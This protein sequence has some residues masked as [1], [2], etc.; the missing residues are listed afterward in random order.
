MKKCN[1]IAGLIVC[2]A[3]LF[4]GCVN[5]GNYVTKEYELPTESVTST[6]EDIN[7]EDYRVQEGAMFS[8]GDL[9]SI[10]GMILENVCFYDENNLVAIFL[11]EEGTRLDAY[12]F[13]LE[14]GSLSW[15]GTIENLTHVEGV[16]SSYTIASVEPLVIMDE[17]TNSMWVLKDKMV[18]QKISLELANVHSIAIGNNKAYYTHLAND[19]IESIDFASGQVETICTGLEEYSYS[20]SKVTQVSEDGKYLYAVGI[21]K[22][23]VTDTTFVIDLEQ[24]KIVAEVCGIFECYNSNDYMYSVSKEDQVYTIHQR[25]NNNYTDVTVG[26]LV[27]YNYFEYFIIEDDVA[28]TEE[29]DGGI[30]T[31][32]YYDIKDMKRIKSTNLDVHSLFMYKYS[33][34]CNFSYCSIN[35]KLGYNAERNMLVYM[36]RTDEGFCDVFLWDIENATKD[37]AS[38]SGEDYTEEMDIQH[39]NEIDYDELTDLVYAIYAKYGVAI[40][41]GANVPTRFTDFTA[42]REEDVAVMTESINAVYEVLQ[43]YPGDFF[44]FFTED[45]YLRGINIYLV[46]SI[47]PVSEGY[48]DNPMGFANISSGYEIITINVNYGDDIKE[49]L[50]HEF[51]HAIYE[52]IEYEELITQNTYF[53]EEKWNGYNPTGFTYYNAYIDSKGNDITINDNGEYTSEKYV[54][55]ESLANIYFIDDYSKTFL[56]EDLA[57]LMQYGMFCETEPYMKSAKIKTKLNYYYSVIRTV[58]DS[59]GWPDKTDWESKLSK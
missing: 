11:N 23:S 56:T 28:I 47:T 50:V 31:F 35:E 14:K 48:M 4:S 3:M 36:V 53:D 7:L 51:S 44:K 10:K 40:Y 29:N 6:Q 55:D 49:T 33:Q 26:E 32:I 25:T 1:G 16:Y 15:L 2:I 54:D 46:G 18:Q 37:G 17:Y 42:V 59:E 52:R 57:R 20:I 5:S 9:I 43:C 24:K 27:P 12:M 8:L 21:S 19:A 58:W 34:A 38:L 41:Y 22:L 30:Y 45:D 13:S 39:I